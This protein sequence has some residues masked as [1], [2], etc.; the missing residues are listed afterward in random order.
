MVALAENAIRGGIV[1]EG[2]GAPT[3]VA[4][5]GGEIKAVGDPECLP[6]THPDYAT[7][8]AMGKPECWCFV[9]QCHGDA[10]DA[11]EEIAKGVYAR[12]AFNDIDMLLDGYSLPDSDPNFAIWIA[13]DFDH[14]QEEI[15]KGVYARVAFNDIDILLKYYSEPDVNVPADCQSCNPVDD[16]PNDPNE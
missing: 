15:A 1:L 14:A 10:D 2:A 6:T 5:P 3:S 7:W 16:D 12:V 11:Q 8:V 4:L 9:S 13:A